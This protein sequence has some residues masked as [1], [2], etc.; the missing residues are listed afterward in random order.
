M[1]KRTDDLYNENND[2]QFNFTDTDNAAATAYTAN[3]TVA[4]GNGLLSRVKRKNIVV[5][6]I[7]IIVVLALYKLFGLFM[8]NSDK[9][10]I[11]EP[12]VQEQVRKPEVVIADKPP[13]APVVLPQVQPVVVN[14][15]QFNDLK[16]Q[17]GM[18]QGNMN[19][20]A[21]RVN[22]LGQVVESLNGQL[23]Q[24]QTS[25]TQMSQSMEKK[26]PAG[27]HKQ[28]VVKKAALPPVL[29]VQA[30]VPGRAWLQSSTGANT[31][32]SVGDMIPGYGVVQMIDVGQGAVYTSSGAIIHYSPNDS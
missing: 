30:M 8:G 25:L 20:L 27:K 3:T 6:I 1:D 5:A 21:N 10:P 12:V 28:T 7:T 23:M 9:N 24:Q 4:K 2:E 31:T 32:V 18:L 15:T 29:Y 14:E 17:M 13:V 19:E 16:N 26:K 22:V 11:K